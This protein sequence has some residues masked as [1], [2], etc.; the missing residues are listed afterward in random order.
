MGHEGENM[1]FWAKK[2]ILRRELT[3]LCAKLKKKISGIIDDI[4]KEIL[5]KFQFD[6]PIVRARGARRVKK[7]LCQKGTFEE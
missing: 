1:N 4:S 3:S 6:T 2:G 5:K 7:K